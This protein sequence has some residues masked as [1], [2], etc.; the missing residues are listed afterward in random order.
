ML[1]YDL[2]PERLGLD[3]SDRVW[4]EKRLAVE[5]A[6]SYACISENTRSDLL[7]LE[8]K[9][10]GK[11]AEVVPLG[12][13]DGFFPA[14]DYE[15]AAFRTQCGL[16]R[17][18]FLVVGERLGVDGYKNASL[19]FRAFRDWSGAGDHE[20]VCVGG[21]AQLEPELRVAGPRVRARRLNL[22]DEELRL[23]YAGAEA[24]VFPSRYEGFG[25]PVIEAM[26]CG[27]PVITTPFSSLPEVAGDAALYVDPDDAASLRQALDVVRD[28]ERRAAMIAAGKIRAKVL[29]WDV[30]A[31]AFA[32]VLTAATQTAE[33]DERAARDAVWGSLRR[34][35]AHEETTSS[36]GRRRPDRE[37][38]TTRV[39]SLSQRVE[40]LALFYLPP[41][42]A[43]R[44]RAVKAS[45]R[46]VLRTRVA[47]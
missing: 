1:V 7:E 12:V 17:P 15:V 36:G 18:Y 22:G 10:R 9:S 16:D 29:T 4:A 20:I 34:G 28:P 13:D 41:R 44:L 3:L 14:S 32:S 26:A 27:C 39:S 19:V 8:P 42:A 11:H 47:G 21:R 23:A 2:I 25:L 37:P 35:Q 30:A 38:R 24:L 33:S 5:H 43:A 31:A 46:R 6:S 45:I 40:T